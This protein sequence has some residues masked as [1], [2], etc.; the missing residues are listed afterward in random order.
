MQIHTFVLGP[1]STNAYL[2]VRPGTKRALVLDPGGDPAPLVEHIQQAGLQV[3]A[4][5]LTHAHWDHIAGLDEVRE[6]TQW[7]PVYLSA[8]EESWTG[9]TE[10]NGSA[11]WLKDG[12]TVSKPVENLVQG[13]PLLSF[14]G[15]EIQVI[16]TPGHTPG[17]LSYKMDQVIFCGD[18]VFRGSVGRTDLY[19]GDAQ[20]LRNSLR[21]LAIF[22]SAGTRLLPGHGPATTWGYEQEHNPWLQVGRSPW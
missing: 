20:V 7:P 12:C 1:V 19:G 6:A 17:S 13:E 22:S 16:S 2:V 18:L 8:V 9:D 11:R 4:I 3:E 15:K 10:K 14:L 21:H 5:L